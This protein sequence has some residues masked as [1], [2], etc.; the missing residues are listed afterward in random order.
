VYA[1]YA[2]GSVRDVTA[3]A[4][5]ESSNTEVATCDKQGL[6]TAVRR[7]EATALA[8]YEG[9]Y[10]ATTLVVMGDRGGF[11][12]KDVPTNNYIDE[13]VY[14]KLKRVKVQPSDLCPD[15]DF[16]R[17]LYLDLTGLPPQPEAV[18]AFL[19]DPRPTKVKRDELIDQLVGGPEYVEHWTNKWADLL[20]VNRKFLGDPGAKALR[21][22]IR[23]SVAANK[24]Y[25]KFVHEVLTAS[26][27]NVE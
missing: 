2:D 6:L 9:A 26:G 25:D 8:R 27:S 21:E 24:P 18:R 13:L 7:G 10:T 19:A 23:A 17:R 3:E 14:E 1:T 16:I 15:A 5:I 22:Y 20:Q 11:V 12:W 4:F